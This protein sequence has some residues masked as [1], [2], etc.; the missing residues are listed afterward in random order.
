M[1]VAAADVPR[2]SFERSIGHAT[3][4]VNNAEQ[5]GGAFVLVLLEA[6]AAL[7]GSSM[8]TA[9]RSEVVMVVMDVKSG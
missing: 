1:S 7:L 8:G 3:Y 4:Q 2:R 9:G 5:V 6:A